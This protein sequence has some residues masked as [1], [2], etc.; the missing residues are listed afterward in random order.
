MLRTIFV[1]H[2]SVLLQLLDK[3]SLIQKR[4]HSIKTYARSFLI[5][6]LSVMAATDDYSCNIV[7]PMQKVHVHDL[8]ATILHLMV[9]DHLRLI[10]S[11]QGCDFRLTDVHGE[12][13]H[14]VLS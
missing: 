4:Y 10:C 9:I 12:V 5:G 3:V 7:T 8:N 14:G 11:Y 1:L 6:A 2:F 13:A